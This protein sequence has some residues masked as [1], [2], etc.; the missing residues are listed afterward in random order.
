[1]NAVVIDNIYDRVELNHISYESLQSSHGSDRE[2]N[3]SA[4]CRN[5]GGGGGAGLCDEPAANDNSSK[6]THIA[7]RS[8]SSLFGAEQTPGSHGISNS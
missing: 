8:E 6:K 3:I 7:N 1:V 4:S 5:H 2:I